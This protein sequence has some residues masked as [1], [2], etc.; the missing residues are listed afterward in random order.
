MAMVRSMIM[1][2]LS[3]LIRTELSDPRIGIFSITDINI[4]RDLHY[5]DVKISVVGGKEATEQCAEVFNGAA[6][7]LWNRLRAETDLRQIP[8][9]RFM[10]D[11]TGEFTDEIEQL[12]Q[13]VK[14]ED[15]LAGR[16]DIAESEDSEA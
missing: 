7:L 12:L 6:P 13:K 1:R 8:K 15:R 14:E 10:A 5:A 3:E 2:T 11:T 4:S 16:L 9:L